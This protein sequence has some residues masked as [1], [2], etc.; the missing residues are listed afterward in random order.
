M[1]FSFKIIKFLVRGISGYLK[2]LEYYNP[3]QAKNKVEN[4]KQ[5]NKK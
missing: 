3:E 1:K 2:A 5:Q 4:K